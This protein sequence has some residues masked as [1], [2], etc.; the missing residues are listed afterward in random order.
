MLIKSKR[1]VFLIAGLLFSLSA[2]ADPIPAERVKMLAGSCANCHGTEGRLTGA[3]PALAGR[4]ASTLETTLL[5]FKHDDD[6]SVTVMN[7]ITRGYSDE[8]LAALADY[9]ANIDDQD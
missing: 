6:A 4:P 3:V 5:S 8:E 1:S 9:F 2:Q 7:R